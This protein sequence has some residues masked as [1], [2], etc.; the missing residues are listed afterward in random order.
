MVPARL[1]LS[2]LGHR[3][4]GPGRGWPK[5]QSKLEPESGLEPLPGLAKALPALC[6]ARVSLFRARTLV[7]GAAASHS[8]RFIPRQGTRAV[9]VLQPMW[10]E[11]LCGDGRGAQSGGR[12]QWH[13]PSSEADVPS[14][15][16]EGGGAE[17]GVSG[18]GAPAGRGRPLTAGPRG[19]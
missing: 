9:F 15:V 17:A 18:Q 19:G 16:A 3:W 2:P 4:P 1:C 14:S 10:A 5:R 11:G 13:P 6:Q 7:Q 12:R 8:E